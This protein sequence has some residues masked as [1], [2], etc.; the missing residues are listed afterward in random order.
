MREALYTRRYEMKPANERHDPLSS[1]AEYRKALHGLYTQVLKF[2]ATS[3][4]YLYRNGATRIAL[5]SIKWDDWKSLLLDV[6]N[7]ETSFCS[8][9]DIWK[10][11]RDQEEGEALDERHREHMLAMRTMSRDFSGL[12]NAVAEAQND[13]NRAKLLVWLSAVDPPENFNNAQEKHAAFTGKWLLERNAEFEKWKTAPNSLFWLYG[14]GGISFQ[15]ELFESLLIT[16][17]SSRVRKICS[18]V[19]HWSNSLRRS[20]HIAD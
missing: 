2:Q 17:P 4:C 16:N 15:Y 9:Y 19:S 20:M 1:H 18:K 3:V 8:I 11:T 7:K 6:Q 13:A 12:R 14:K 10:D 5:D